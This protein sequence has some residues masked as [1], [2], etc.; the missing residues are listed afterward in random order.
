M[1]D[2][3]A[4]L[5]AGGAGQRLWP[6]SR[7][8][9]PKQFAPLIGPKSSFQLAVDRI[10]SLVIPE[11]I[12]VGTNR[13][14]RA[15]LQAQAPQIPARNY[16]LEPVRRDVAAAVALAFFT[17]ERDG[18]RGPVFFQWADNYV[19]NVD[20]LLEALDVGHKLV[21][22]NPQRLVLLG[23]EP[24]YPSEN[25]GWIEMGTDLGEIGGLHYYAM[26]SLTYRP[27]RSTCEQMLA[28]GRHVWNSGYFVT[29]VEFMTSSFRALAPELATR[30]EEIVAY[31]GTPDEQPQLDRLYPSVPALHFDEAVLERLPRG[32]ALLLRRDL[33]WSDP[34]NLYSLKEA[35]QATAES[36]VSRGSVVELNTRDSLIYSL[37]EGKPV[38]AMGLDG[39]MVIDTPDVLL[40]VHKDS[41]RHL[42]E[43]LQELERRGYSNLL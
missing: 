42:G 22:E 13:A 9:S 25:L 39:I 11:H 40:V 15:I 37:V 12:F 6:L 21:R 27:P 4:L 16:V 3:R 35:L 34:G 18:A 8:N 30:I 28:S 2:L 20:A 24:R 41:V 33:G 31:R 26:E 19:R 1:S 5:F 32:Q 43:L 29:T 14:H 10:A 38:A 23:Q 36:T 17:L 7:K